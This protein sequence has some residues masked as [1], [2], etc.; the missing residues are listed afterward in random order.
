[1]AGEQK[2]QRTRDIPAW[3]RPWLIPL[4]LVL[5]VVSTVNV[6]LLAAVALVV[7]L[8]IARWRYRQVRAR[9]LKGV[10]EW[11]RWRTDAMLRRAFQKYNERR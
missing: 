6:L 10:H 1:M 8:V 5:V 2:A 7:L 4:L 3:L 11:E 9:E